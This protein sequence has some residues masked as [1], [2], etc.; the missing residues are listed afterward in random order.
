METT[1]SDGKILIEPIID[2]KVHGT[3]SHGRIFRYGLRIK[4]IDERISPDFVIAN[5]TLESADG[6]NIVATEGKAFF[7]PRL[8]ANEEKYFDIGEHGSF[9]HGLVK[10][11]AHLS[12]SDQTKTIACYQRRPFTNSFLFVNSNSWIDFFYIKTPQEK[13]QE[14]IIFRL[15]W[16]TVVVLTFMFLE[17]A[18][19][20]YL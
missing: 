18:F 7:V 12:P 15:K 11:G 5:V 19:R 14:K 8:N 1:F 17:I 10:I 6:Q 16:L 9:M 13:M 20:F 3:P 2:K 4:N